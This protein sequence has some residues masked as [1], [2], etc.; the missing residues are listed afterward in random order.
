ML[1]LAAAHSVARHSAAL[2]KLGVVQQQQQQH[3]AVGFVGA[4]L[5]TPPAGGSTSQLPAGGSANPEVASET[6]AS[7]PQEALAAAAAPEPGLQQ[8]F[9]RVAAAARALLAFDHGQGQGAAPGATPPAA[10]PGAVQQ[11]AGGVTVVLDSLP[12][13]LSLYPDQQQAAAFLHCC[14]ALGASL[15]APAY[16]FVV[17]AAADSPGDAALV[18]QLRHAAD[19]VLALTPVEGRTA[20]LDG[21]LDA[22]LARLPPSWLQRIG[23]DGAG[24][25]AAAVAAA[26]GRPVPGTHS[27]HYRATDVGVRWLPERLGGRELMA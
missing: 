16:R 20:E 9:Q 6:P 11:P 25:G 17:L 4:H 27:W 19:A 22:T 12:C 3:A 13:L 18:A 21:R 5:E 15:G 7:T 24:G 23:D 1:V 10:G 14:R 8:L 2:R 26:E